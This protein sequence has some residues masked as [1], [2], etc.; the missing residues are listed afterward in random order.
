VRTPQPT[1]T[2][3]WKAI[4]LAGPDWPEDLTIPQNDQLPED[5]ECIQESMCTNEHWDWELWRHPDGHCYYLKAWPTDEGEFASK[6]NTP[7]ATLTVMETFHFLMSNWM[8]PDVLA[9]MAFERPDMLKSFDLPP[10]TPGL[11]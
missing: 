8:P 10:G 5:S 7:G 3:N 1:P 9:D 2:P 6:P 11:N 4:I